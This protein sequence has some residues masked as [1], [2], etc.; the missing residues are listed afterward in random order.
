[1]KSAKLEAA[2][3]VVVATIALGAIFGAVSGALSSGWL[4]TGLRVTDGVVFVVAVVVWV[5]SR[6]AISDSHGP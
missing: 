3:G 6:W 5:V 2:K 1:M 4:W